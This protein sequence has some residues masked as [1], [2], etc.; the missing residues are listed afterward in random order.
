MTTDKVKTDEIAAGAKM[1]A[2]LASF[3]MLLVGVAGVGMVGLLLFSTALQDQAFVVNRERDE[4][5][6]LQRKLTGLEAQLAS[7]NTVPTLARRAQDLGM[8]PNPY[9][10]QLVL[11]TGEVVGTAQKISGRE[12]PAATYRTPQEQDDYR[13]AVAMRTAT[14]EQN[15]TAVVNEPN[16]ENL[17]PQRSE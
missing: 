14:A 4:A 11:S 8:K 13:Q 10:A 15:N 16:G 17:P 1:R 2:G 9:A 5:A 3:V 6:A 12:I 7:V